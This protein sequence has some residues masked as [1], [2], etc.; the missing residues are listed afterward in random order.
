MATVQYYLPVGVMTCFSL[1][2]RWPRP[3]ST[4]YIP[5]EIQAT[6]EIHTKE[7]MSIACSYWPIESTD[8]HRIWNH[9]LLWQHRVL[10]CAYLVSERK[11]HC[12]VNI[13][14]C[15]KNPEK[16][17]ITFNIMRLSKDRQL[18]LYKKRLQNIY[19]YIRYLISSLNDIQI[20]VYFTEIMLTKLS[21]NMLND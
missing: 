17:H 5:Q 12:N 21:A 2:G 8:R 19:G 16:V 7:N 9:V 4:T 15:Y 10:L 3:C 6:M 11:Q 14:I 20:G 1:N 18:F 13:Y